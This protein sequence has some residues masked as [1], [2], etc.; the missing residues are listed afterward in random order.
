[1][2]KIPT[3]KP[4]SAAAQTGPLGAG[5]PNVLKRNQVSALPSRCNSIPLITLA[6]H[7]H[8]TNVV[9]V[10]WC[11]HSSSRWRRTSLISDL[12]SD[13]LEM[14]LLQNLYVPE[15]DPDANTPL[16]AMPKS[17]ARPALVLMLMPSLM[18]HQ[19][20]FFRMHQ[21]APTMMVRLR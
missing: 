6:R 9:G 8:A 18:L 2:P 20:S 10:S 11:V 12:I 15:P 7:R 21:S 1:M 16:I 4:I 13:H 5:H 17:L 19:E 14:V 3:A